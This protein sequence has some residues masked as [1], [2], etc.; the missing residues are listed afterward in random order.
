MGLEGRTVNGVARN[1]ILVGFMGTGKS[2]I[3]A[4]LAERLGWRFCDTDE[5][6]VA[7]EGLTIPELFAQRGEAYFRDAESAVLAAAL[8]GAKQVVSTGGGAVLR[9]SNRDAMRRGGFVVALSA[10]AEVL[11]ERLRGDANRP[12][13]GGDE[14]RR[15]HD[16]LAQRQGA[17]DFAALTIDTSTC[18]VKEAVETI[19]GRSGALR[20]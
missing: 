9:A 19:I 12:L 8:E 17:Y 1:I 11:L 15:V 5:S 10:P 4:A 2:T 3:G 7:R 13:L 20:R 16:L 18:N 14:E 6:I